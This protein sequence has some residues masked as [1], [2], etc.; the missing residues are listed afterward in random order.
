[1]RKNMLNK[2]LTL[3]C[4]MALF[5][6]AAKKQIAVERKADTTAA[7]TAAINAPGQSDT[8]D[9][10]KAEKINTIKLKQTGFNTFSGK[11]S[12]KLNID[13]KEDNVTMNIR[14]R[15][16]EGIWVAI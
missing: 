1:M 6:C 13:G 3:T 11:A 7:K 9:H 2:L 14:I 4:A 12:A 10:F 8:V 5:G 16:G 15:K